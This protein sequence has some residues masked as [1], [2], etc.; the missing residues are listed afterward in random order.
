M[1]D[2]GKSW[3]LDLLEMY[4]KYQGGKQ[5]R[6]DLDDAHND[7]M[8]QWEK[9]YWRSTSPYMAEAI[10]PMLQAVLQEQFRVYNE[11]R[12]KRGGTGLDLAKIFAPMLSGAGQFPSLG[13]APGGMQ[14]AGG[15]RGQ[16]A[17][18]GP[19]MSGPGISLGSG[20]G[21]PSAGGAGA[22]D[23]GS[24]FAGGS[25][26]GSSGGGADDGRNWAD[27]FGDWTAAHPNLFNNAGKVGAGASFLTG[28]PL[29]AIIGK[30]IGGVDNAAAFL[31]RRFGNVDGDAAAANPFLG[32]LLDG[33]AGFNGAPSNG[34]SSGGFSFDGQP[35]GRD[36]DSSGQ[37]MFGSGAGQSQGSQFSLGLGEDRNS[38]FGS[39]ALGTGPS[40]QEQIRIWEQADPNPYGFAGLMQGGMHAGTASPWDWGDGGGGGLGGFSD[41]P[42]AGGRRMI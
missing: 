16:D 37:G 25:A 12:E 41:D 8:A 21:A 10:N 4:S 24:M 20:G 27:K 23:L 6:E 33:G 31:D 42:W 35:N 40:L 38:M 28:N 17:A 19:S 39:G 13:G 18:P 29:A 22:Y 3:W 14:G 30:L 15:Q 7:A 34:G 2:S 1:A 36:F 32:R 5:A 9:G 11:G 26:S